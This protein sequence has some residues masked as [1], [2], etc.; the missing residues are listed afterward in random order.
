M[1]QGSD[2]GI[3]M[4]T[5]TVPNAELIPAIGKL[6]EEGQEVIFKPKG[7]SMLPFIRGG[8]DS[9]LLRKA[10]ELKVGDIALAEISE[11]RYVLHRIEMIEGETIVLMGDGN[12]VGREK[13]RREDVMAIA[14]KIIKDR[15]E[16]DCQ[17]QGH[18]RNAEIWRRLLPVR[19]YLLAIYRRII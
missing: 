18:L 13:C 5:K 8:R 19:R 10:D 3:A 17:S 9:V 14:V 12:L 6:I 16:I 1:L 2:G 7:M 15:R 4:Q 11:G